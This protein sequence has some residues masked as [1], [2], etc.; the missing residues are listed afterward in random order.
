[1]KLEW[2]LECCQC[3]RELKFPAKPCDVIFDM[4]PIRVKHPASHLPEDWH[5][6]GLGGWLCGRC[7]SW[8][9]SEGMAKAREGYEVQDLVKELGSPHL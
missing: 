8:W 3:N 6:D 5:N 1:M 4:D 2:T 9:Q 7:Y